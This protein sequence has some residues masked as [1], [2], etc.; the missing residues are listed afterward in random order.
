MIKKNSAEEYQNLLKKFPKIRPTLSQKY[1]DIY[2]QHYISNREGNGFANLLS[3]KMEAW[4]HKKTSSI[5]GKNILELGAGNLNH[6]VYENDYNNYDIVEPFSDLYKDS[7]NLSSVRNIFNSLSEVNNKYDKILSIATL[8]HLVDLPKEIQLCKN[9]LQEEGIFQ[10]AI[11]CE[12]ELAFRLGWMLTT[13]ITF[14][15]KYNLD[16]ARLMQ[17]EHINSI[18]EIYNILENNF[19]IVKFQRSPFLFPLK[20]FSFYA[21]FECKLN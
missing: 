19:S 15:I 18:N 9:L 20:H 8:E 5:N 6:I 4:M 1:K 7:P 2:N 14:R 3:Q 12:G 13:G 10:V 16:Y 21:Y 11:P 17:Y